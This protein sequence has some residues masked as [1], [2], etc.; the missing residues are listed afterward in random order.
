MYTGAYAVEI[1]SAGLKYGIDPMLIASVI[2]AESGFNPNAKSPAGAGGLMQLMP[3]TA[4]GLGV[5]DVFNPS[6]NID[7]GSRYLAQ[8]IKNFNSIELGLAAYN[9]GPGNVKKYGGIPQFKETQ[10]YVKKVMGYYDKGAKTAFPFTPGT[11]GEKVEG[12]T[13]IGL[14][15]K[16]IFNTPFIWVS[17]LV[18]FLLK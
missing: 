7:G 14:D 10:K 11:S 4:R 6:Q 9:A 3:A 13:G 5:H 2:K 12:T 17:L 15:L 1:N 8:Q 16:A 18:I